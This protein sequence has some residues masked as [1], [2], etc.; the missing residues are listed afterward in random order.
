VCLDGLD[1]GKVFDK[2]G[3]QIEGIFATKG[4]TLVI[5]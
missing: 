5:R 4:S 3:N 1:Y 2:D